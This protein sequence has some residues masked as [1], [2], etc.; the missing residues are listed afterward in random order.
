MQS[1]SSD[2][3]SG[4]QFAFEVT[5]KTFQAVYVVAIV[6]ITIFAMLNCSGLKK[7]NCTELM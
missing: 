1:F 6:N 7:I 4:G 5:P 2:A 3:T